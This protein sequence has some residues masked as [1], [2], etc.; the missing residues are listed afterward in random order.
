MFGVHQVSYGDDN[1]D[2]G[3]GDGDG[4][5]DVDVDVNGARW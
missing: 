3:D 2:D 5:S 1:G 4:G